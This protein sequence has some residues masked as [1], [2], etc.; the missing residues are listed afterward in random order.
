MKP[1]PRMAATAN[2]AI[3]KTGTAICLT[4]VPEL[5]STINEIFLAIPHTAAIK[6]NYSNNSNIYTI[7]VHKTGKGYHDTDKIV[8]TMAA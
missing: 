5:L 4:V 3:R 8:N 6:R 7:S 1:V 2:N